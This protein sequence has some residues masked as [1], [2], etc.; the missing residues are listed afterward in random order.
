[1]LNELHEGRVV[2]LFKFVPNELGN[3]KGKE[4]PDILAQ[5]AARLR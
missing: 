3:G 5:R 1:M 4:P 2:P